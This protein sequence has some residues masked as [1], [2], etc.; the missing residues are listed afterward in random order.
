MQTNVLRT[1]GNSLNILKIDNK[2][3][4]YSD[5]GNTMKLKPDSKIKKKLE[6]IKESFENS[7]ENEEKPTGAKLIKILATNSINLPPKMQE[8]DIE[9][10]ERVN[11]D[12]LN[13]ID[14]MVSQQPVITRHYDISTVLVDQNADPKKI[15]TDLRQDEIPTITSPTL[16]KPRINM[17]KKVQTVAKIDNKVQKNTKISD[18]SSSDNNNPKIE[19]KNN[20]PHIDETN[21]TKK[22]QLIDIFDENLNNNKNNDIKF[23]ENVKLDLDVLDFT[24]MDIE[25]TINNDTSETSNNDLQIDENHDVICSDSIENTSRSSRKKV[26]STSNDIGVPNNDNT[27]QDND[28]SFLNNENS[29]PNNDNSTPNN[30][31]STPNNDNSSPHIDNFRPNNDKAPPN[32]DKI[33]PNNDKS[34][35][36]NVVDSTQNNRNVLDNDTFQY[37]VMMIKMFLAQL[38]ISF[39]SIYEFM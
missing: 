16:P 25:S 21:V 23:N 35:P 8:I 34:S 24:E 17:I 9:K 29:V 39:N 33:P 18:K 15:D 4:I 20:K 3:Q 1:Y 2:K 7:K 12:M 22:L 14:K 10:R 26:T 28:N 5:E 36:N 30:D 38:S 13:M 31:N 37:N 32:N 11:R 6:T 19:V 27:F